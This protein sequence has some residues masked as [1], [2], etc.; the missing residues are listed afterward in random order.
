MKRYRFGVAVLLILETI[1][2]AGLGLLVG[3]A[4]SPTH[5]GSVVFWSLASFLFGVFV[6]LSEILSH[7]R[8]EPLRA[9]ATSAGL[10]YLVLNGLFSLSAFAVLRIYPDKIFPAL[11]NDYLMTSVVA[12]F[13]AMAVFR[14]KLFTFHTGDGKDIPIGPAIVL[15]TIFRTI[16]SKIDRRR[17]TE[18]QEKVFDAMIG[19]HDFNSTASYI[20]ASLSSF[21]NL[22][23]EDKAQITGVIDQYRKVPNWP[24]TLKSM[25]LGFAFLNI[26]GEENF[27]QVID[28]LKRFI[29]DQK[30]SGGPPAAPAGPQ[31]PQN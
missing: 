27:D 18:R 28:N 4:T 2:V 29:A 31:S 30:S 12:G 6:G 19:I 22:S 21:Q 7:Y 17:A 3:R 24:D 23:Q 16:D 14:S 26:A 1:S 9:A 11:A 20:E 8:D 15:D 25:S 10:A 13:G 5:T